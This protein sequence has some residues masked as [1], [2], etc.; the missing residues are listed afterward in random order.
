[1]SNNEQPETLSINVAETIRIKDVPPGTAAP[2][3]KEK[4]EALP[5]EEVE[6]RQK[7]ML[8]YARLSGRYCPVHNKKGRWVQKADVPQVLADGKDMSTMCGLPHGRYGA[9][10][11]LAHTQIDDKDP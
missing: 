1:M 3:S 10:S 9:I 8:E 5:P 7:M 4:E 6:K 11:A 2:S